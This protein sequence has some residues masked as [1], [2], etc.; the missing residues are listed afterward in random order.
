[1][2]NGLND[3]ETLRDILDTSDIDSKTP[4]EA[5]VLIELMKDLSAGQ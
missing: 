1:M 3:N 5:T 4:N 2:L